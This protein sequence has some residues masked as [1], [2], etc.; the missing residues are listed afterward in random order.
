MGDRKVEGTIESEARIRCPL[1]GTDFD[2]NE[3]GR[4]SI[5]P[6]G[7]NCYLICCPVCG[8][9]IVDER[10]S[11]LARLARRLHVAVTQSRR[12]KP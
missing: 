8:Y 6:L 2:A 5:C 12:G 7:R 1:C 10:K 3:H 4:C 11:T 9:Q